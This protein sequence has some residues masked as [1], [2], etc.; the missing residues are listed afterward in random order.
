MLGP[1]IHALL[2]G[3]GKIAPLVSTGFSLA[4]KFIP[5]ALESGFIPSTIANVLT[6]GMNFL[7][8]AMGVYNM[9][10]QVASTVNAKRKA[11]DLAKLENKISGKRKRMA[12]MESFKPEEFQA[13]MNNAVY[14]DSGPGPGEQMDFLAE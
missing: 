13:A 3:L 4:Q 10:K 5:I 1:G 8:K 12:T 11:A 14:G 6:T 7:G 2:G 9:A